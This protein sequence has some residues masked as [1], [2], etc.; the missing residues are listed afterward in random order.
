MQAVGRNDIYNFA[1][2]IAGQADNKPL[3]VIDGYPYFARDLVFRTALDMYREKWGSMPI[4]KV[5]EGCDL[6]WGL[7]Q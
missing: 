3:V 1:K 2:A 7:R 4:A 5:V 6:V